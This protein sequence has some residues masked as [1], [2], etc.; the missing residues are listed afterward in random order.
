M[1]ARYTCACLFRNAEHVII[2]R[3][4]NEARL[5]SSE[6]LADVE[7]LETDDNGLDGLLGARS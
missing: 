5:A 3:Y 6:C 1:F 7:S 2:T 4:I